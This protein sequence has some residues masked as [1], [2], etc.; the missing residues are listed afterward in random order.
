MLYRV[1][2]CEFAILFE[3]G[4]KIKISSE[5]Y[6]PLKSLESLLF[7]VRPKR[8]KKKTMGGPLHHPPPC[9][10]GWPQLELFCPHWC[11]RKNHQLVSLE[12]LEDVLR[13][14]YFFF[15]IFSCCLK[16]KL[17]ENILGCIQE[18]FYRFSMGC[19]P[20]KIVQENILKCSKLINFNNKF[21][22][23]CLAWSCYYET[24]CFVK[25]LGDIS[26]LK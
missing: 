5:I 15:I 25:F 24:G 18:Q 7:T 26:I 10:I 20:R 14:W 19:M 2:D 11:A 17:V 1:K 22:P 8:T 16:M 3:D 6:Q 23:E 13:S 9:Q 21:K 12:M 4:T